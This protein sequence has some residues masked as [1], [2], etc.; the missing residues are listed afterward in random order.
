MNLI[1]KTSI[2]LFL[3]CVCAVVPTISSAIDSI[4]L[5]YGRG[6]KTEMVRI[7]AQWRWNQQWWKSNGSHIGGYWSLTAAHWRQNRF[8]GI[9]GN[10]QDI[11][12]LGI[13]PVFRFQN[14]SLKGFY[15]E[16][17]IGTHLLSE[18][19]DN[20]GKQLSTRFQFGDHIGA[21]YIFPNNVD[22]GVSIQH[23]SNGGIKKPNDGV[24]FAII[25]LIYPL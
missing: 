10:K 4:S 18:L 25:R 12:S 15:A 8:Q 14:D 1:P 3:A 22:L 24:N 21:G 23:F 7:G 13:T 5:E 9:S 6:D 17:G 19:Y 2:S 16:A 20:D 11:S